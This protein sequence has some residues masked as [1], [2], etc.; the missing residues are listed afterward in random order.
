MFC[1]YCGEE[2]ADDAKFCSHCG[3][4]IPVIEKEQHPATGEVPAAEATVSTDI[5]HP[6]AEEEASTEISSPTSITEDRLIIEPADDNEIAPE[7]EPEEPKDNSGKIVLVAVLLFVLLLIL[8]GFWVIKDTQKNSSE[9]PVAEEQEEETDEAVGE[10]ITS[11]SDISAERLAGM[12]DHAKSVLDIQLKNTTSGRET[13]SEMTYLGN[14]TLVNKSYEENGGYNNI[15]Y[16]V[17]HVTTVNSYGTEKGSYYWY[18]GYHDIQIKAD[19]D[20]S[21]D[22]TATAT[23]TVQTDGY[24]GYASLDELYQ[25][26]VKDNRG[27]YIFEDNVEDIEQPEEETP[28]EETEQTEDTTESEETEETEETEDT[29]VTTSADGQIF[30]DSS[31][32]LLTDAQISSLSA[33][34]IR[35]AVNEIYAR[36]GY[37][38]NDSSLQSYYEQYSWYTP[39]TSAAN[40][41]ESVFN[42]TEQQNI[43]NLRAKL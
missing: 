33:T 35:Y 34:Q 10:F 20:S 6:A 11:S 2:I 4:K 12:Q 43:M 1:I 13:V 9:E 8:L 36:H 28:E 24:Y 7:E 38:F 17:Y 29:A 26:V 14:Y 23:P 5:E 3:K 37:I 15:F 27:Q 41:S 32:V 18:I 19:D 21:A 31:S 42:Y 16:L 39:T 25:S 30:P 22:Y 40:F